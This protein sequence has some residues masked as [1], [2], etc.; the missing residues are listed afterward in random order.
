MLYPFL[1]AGSI[2]IEAPNDV[3]GKLK[4][5]LPGLVNIFKGGPISLVI[6]D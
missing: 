5:F 6:C 1:A 4:N 2:I 3:C